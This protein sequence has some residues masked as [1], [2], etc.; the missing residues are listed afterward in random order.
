M[1]TKLISLSIVL[2]LT[3]FSALSQRSKPGSRLT[4]AGYWIH[5][6]VEEI[7]WLRSGPFVKLGD[8]ISSEVAH[9]NNREELSVMFSEDDGKT[10]NDPVVIAGVTEKSKV[11]NLAYPRFF[12]PLPG[13]IWITTTYGGFAGYL[14]VK[15]FEKDFTG[16]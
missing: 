10:W 4:P 5:D 13:E 6:K 1:K 7:P 2:F 8:G 16:N 15:L 9:S 14:A 3:C 11:K 12:E